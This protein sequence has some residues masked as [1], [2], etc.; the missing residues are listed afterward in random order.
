M[1]NVKA[2][3]LHPPFLV[4]FRNAADYKAGSTLVAVVVKALKSRLRRSRR[5]DPHP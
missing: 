3:T 4:A 5:S 2:H 1:S